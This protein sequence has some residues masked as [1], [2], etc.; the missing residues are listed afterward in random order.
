MSPA[1]QK[2][3]E[4]Q[5]ARTRKA[6]SRQASAA[7]N[8]AANAY[9]PA[10]G[11]FHVLESVSGPNHNGRFRS[12]D[13]IVDSPSSNGVG[14]EFDSISNNGSCSGESE[15]QLHINGKEKHAA[16]KV[17]PPPGLAG[18]L[19]KRDKLHRKNER[20][21]QRQKERRT[22][23]LRDKCIGYLMSRKLEALSQQLVLMGF[24]KER[25]TMALIL[26]DGR[27]EQSVSWLLEG[28]EGQTQE[29]WNAGG[30]PKIDISEELGQM[31]EIE[32][33]YKV[34]RS[35]I[36][37]AI[38]SCE[39]DLNKALESLRVRT[40]NSSSG[41]AEGHEL[42][43]VSNGISENLKE[44]SLVSEKVMPGSSGAL[45]TTVSGRF[46]AHQIRQE[47][48]DP[49]PTKGR[50]QGIAKYS[51]LDQPAK[52]F[53][54]ESSISNPLSNLQRTFSPAEHRGYS[55]RSVQPFCSQ[56]ASLPCQESR[57][58]SYTQ[59][60]SLPYVSPYNYAADSRVNT[61][62]IFCS[63]GTDA[64]MIHSPARDFLGNTSLQ[65]PVSPQFSYTS[66][67]A[68]GLSAFSVSPSPATSW[69]CGS[70][71][72]GSPSS[73]LHV[74]SISADGGLNVGKKLAGNLNMW[75][76]DLQGQFKSLGS[77]QSDSIST[78][79]SLVGNGLSNLDTNS[80]V[81]SSGL[82]TGWGSEFSRSSVDW[83][84][85]PMDCDY[86]KI[87]WS[88]SASPSMMKSA[89]FM[90]GLSSGLAS[91]TLQEKC[92]SGWNLEESRYQGISGTAN[93]LNESSNE[94]GILKASS[95]KL[96]AQD[97]TRGEPG[98]HEWTSPF[99]GKDLFTLPHA[100]PSPSL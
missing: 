1:K 92:G 73:V 94:H 78:D 89:G 32:K 91:L 15:D 99:T 23:E 47:D 36:E 33:Q 54:Q 48:I 72:G 60:A 77:T 29:E 11:T 70:V 67:P 88:M 38:V 51:P 69:H 18:D 82:Y 40:Q 76:A 71:D 30:D 41:C 14:A 100:V 93:S 80:L 61:G 58:P 50:V 85:G 86:K 37:R 24:S 96:G 8:T 79:W 57:L 26:N 17:E 2:S 12:K 52:G 16:G 84:M 39:G 46:H 97:K 19:D 13:D 81:T 65:K 6:P 10:S 62:F 28:C 74:N 64:K 20:K 21:H 59:T 87:D 55:H 43:G 27:V 63:S 83:S 7:G 5:G 22:Q 75:G 4:K 95:F 31:A 3:N 66:Q 25:A 44:P 90:Q 98:V 45:Q 49:T 68:A 35:E 53:L 56:T 42:H 34:T 9:N